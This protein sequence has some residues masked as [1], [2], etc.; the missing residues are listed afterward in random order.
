[1]G[2]SFRSLT[3]ATR[4][5]IDD[6]ARV[7]EAARVE[8]RFQVAH[9]GVGRGAPFL[10]DEGRH[11]SPGA[12]FGFQRAVVLARH[13]FHD[14]G[15]EMI[16]ALD[17]GR[18]VEG[19]C[20]DEVQVA[21]LCVTENGALGVA[22]HMEQAL[23]IGDAF[24]QARQR[25]SNILDEQRRPLPAGRA[26]R[27]DHALAQ[28]PQRG[29]FERVLR[30]TRLASSFKFAAGGR[31]GP[32]I[33]IEPFGAVILV[34][35][36]DGRGAFWKR[37]QDGRRT[38]QVLDRAQS[39]AIHDLEAHAQIPQGQDGITRILRGVEIQ[40]ARVFERI[41]RQGVQRHL[42]DEAQCAF[43]ANHQVGENIERVFVIEQ[44]VQRVAVGVLG[45][46]ADAHALAQGFI[47]Q[48]TRPQV[49]QAFPNF[50]RFAFEFSFRVRR[51]SVNDQT[52]GKNEGQRV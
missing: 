16:E 43:R 32:T 19:L 30:E 23:Q 20:D 40:H 52:V 2:R 48:H 34:F 7:E 14:V 24:R 45:L 49:E 17:F 1:M 15:H 4:I 33:I 37:R 27:R 42:G 31:R 51:R 18:G 26:N 29:L 44:G 36:Q 13:Q 47:G 35:D 9:D 11:V 12:V 22:V 50:R 21:V 5:G 38:G 10:L 8:Q 25:K 46:V 3:W 39:G 41:I 28:F 6:H